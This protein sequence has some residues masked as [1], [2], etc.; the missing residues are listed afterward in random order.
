[1][2]YGKITTYRAVPEIVDGKGFT[3]ISIPAI[4]SF[5]R[6]VFGNELVIKTMPLYEIGL[7]RCLGC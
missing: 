2:R 6:L 1:M 4:L 5:S 7:T 3:R